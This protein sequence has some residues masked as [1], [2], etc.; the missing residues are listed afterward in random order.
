MNE[1]FAS[2]AQNCSGKVPRIAM[3]AKAASELEKLEALPRGPSATSALNVVPLVVRNLS[4]DLKKAG[5]IRSVTG[6]DFTC[7]RVSS[8]YSAFSLFRTRL[9]TKSQVTVK[10][11]VQ[12]VG[13]PHFKVI[14]GRSKRVLPITVQENPDGTWLLECVPICNGT[15][16]IRVCIFDRWIEEDVPTS[17]VDGELKEG[18]VVRRGPDST[19]TT[20]EFLKSKGEEVKMADI[21]QYNVGKLKTVTRTYIGK[22]NVFHR[23]IT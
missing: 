1:R 3:I 21:S 14:Y 12:P 18:D 16:T 7:S 15:H 6:S 20:E 2:K 13:T 4:T 9:G 19:S 5:L 22:I 11:S 10:S 17:T 8:T 23:R